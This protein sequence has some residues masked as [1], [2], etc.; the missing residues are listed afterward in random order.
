MPGDRALPGPGRAIDG[1]DHLP[2]GL[3]GAQR[4]CKRI[5]PR[6]FVPC[7]G[8]AVKP[9]RLL[10]PAPAPAVIAGLRFPRAGRASAL[11]ART[12]LRLT[13]PGLADVFM[14]FVCP[15][16]FF[17]AGA[18]DL[19][20]RAVPEPLDGR[21]DP[22]FSFAPLELDEA[23][24]PLLLPLTLLGALLPQRAAADDRAPFW[25]L[26]LDVRALEDRASAPRRTGRL[27]L[28]D[29]PGLPAV[30]GLRSR[31]WDAGRLKCGRAAA[32]LAATAGLRTGVR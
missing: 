24:T 13:A 29:W 9:N 6:F 10:L 25:G 32:D 15:L 3:S 31:L 19:P 30:A 22:P 8:R 26:V 16:R 18:V 23:W 17:Q 21:A 2:C 27:P 12:T 7:L 11:R 20:F 4:V 5:H 14:P 28:E 1:D